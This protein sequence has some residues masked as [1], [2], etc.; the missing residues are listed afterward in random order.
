MNRSES[1]YFN[2][3]RLMDEAL[4]SLLE[5]KDLSYITVKEIC[6]RA[7]VNRSTF[8]LHY[9]TVGDL[10][11][12]CLEYTEKIFYASFLDSQKA[13]ID[14]IPGAPREKLIFINREYLIPYL[15]FIRDNK[16]VYVA[17]HKNPAGMKTN[18]QFEQMSR[19]ILQ[20]ILS[21]FGVPIEEQRYWIA[22]YIRGCAAIVNEWIATDFKESVDEIAEIMIRCIRPHTYAEGEME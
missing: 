22:F 15:T 3:A 6:E 14:S 18:K 21:R 7:G 12:E 8:Y 13:F 20:P 19:S 1:K 16:S 10:L 2:T 9:E 4:L 17:A 5:K 11:C